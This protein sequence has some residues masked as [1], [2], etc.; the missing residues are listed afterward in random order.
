MIE[1]LERALPAD[2]D[3]TLNK[4]SWTPPPI[5]PFLQKLGTTRSEMFKVFNMGVGFVFVVRPFFAE[6]VMRVLRRAG[7]EPFILGH[8]R[9]GKQ[10]VRFG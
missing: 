10:R 7:E 4:K 5:F 9:R 1:N 2:C 3:A 6:G 8:V